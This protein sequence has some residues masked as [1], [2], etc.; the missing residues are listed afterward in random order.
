M[1]TKRKKLTI[2]E[3]VNIVHEVENNPN[4]PTI[5]KARKFNGRKCCSH[6]VY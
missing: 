2:L 1:A 6:C 3:K 5:E 4:M